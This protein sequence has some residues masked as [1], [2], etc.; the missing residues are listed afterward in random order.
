MGAGF[1]HNFRRNRHSTYLPLIWSCVKVYRHPL[2]HSL[3]LCIIGVQLFLW[4]QCPWVFFE[5]E[6]G[7]GTYLIKVCLFEYEAGSH[8]NAKQSLTA[9]DGK[10]LD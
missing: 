1:A 4:F 3:N 10:A 8:N 5:T 7:I 9:H 2:S 6:L